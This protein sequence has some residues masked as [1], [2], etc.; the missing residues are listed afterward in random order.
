[1]NRAYRLT[2]EGD[3]A[4]G[5][6]KQIELESY[7]RLSDVIRLNKEL[8]SILPVLNQIQNSGKE[9]YEN[10]FIS[11]SGVIVSNSNKNSNG[12][13]SG[14]SVCPVA[15]VS[16]GDELCG[17]RESL[18]DFSDVANLNPRYKIRE[19]VFGSNELSGDESKY[20]IS[21]SGT[22]YR[23]Q[24]NN[25]VYPLM[26]LVDG[27]C[28]LGKGFGFKMPSFKAPKLP[29]FKAPKLNFKAP[30]IPKIKAPKLNLKLPKIPK[31][32]TKPITSAISS[33]GKSVSKIGQSLS[34]GMSSAGKSISSAGQ[35][36]TK[37]IS[38][39]V[40][41]YG[42]MWKN[43]GKTLEKGVSSAGKA[44]EKGV[45]SIAK[46]AGDLAQGLMNQGQGE[47]TQEEQS[48]DD[49]DLQESAA[50]LDE[51]IS[52]S[53]DA[54]DDSYAQDASELTSEYA[55]NVQSLE[56]DQDIE[57]SEALSDLENAQTQ[58]ELDSASEELN[59]IENSY[60]EKLNNLN[61]EYLARMSELE[62]C[63]HSARQKLEDAI[64]DTANNIATLSGELGLDLS[65]I[66]GLAN[67]GA[68]AYQKGG[69][70]GVA[71]LAATGID[72]LVPG[73]GT[74]AQT[75]LS[76]L[77]NSNQANAAKKAAQKKQ[78]MGILSALAKQQGINLPG[79][80]QKKAPAKVNLP[81]R[82]Q[83]KKTPPVASA[84]II[85]K[86]NQNTAKQKLKSTAINPSKQNLQSTAQ[87]SS[88]SSG[89][90]MVIVGV[91]AAG[92]ALYAMSGKSNKKGER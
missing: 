78:Q 7:Y 10:L 31:L 23:Q 30:K 43:A 65:S 58:D 88:G 86:T 27:D 33:A 38:S 85:A 6:T 61:N 17:A 70:S 68:S 82:T 5:Q 55:D 84:K 16:F 9:N 89:S 8:K 75:G 60:N 13:L 91:A 48:S 4:I 63:Y 77:S 15:Q 92:I 83:V 11:E 3:Q 19:A 39:G 45:S 37:T 47:Q 18:Y 76:I 35:S 56:D 80:T 34:K 87:G 57:S 50:N 32:N 64:A 49:Q 42:D 21:N 44:L 26:H 90:G 29:S 22:V 46:G 72:A 73:A 59:G 12:I 20:Y 52:D 51:A 81:P 69:T 28:E 53:I 71:N 14:Q 40:K 1:M 25:S 66:I 74:L 62:G 79:T 24:S 41:S 36:I 54:V 2:L 67:K